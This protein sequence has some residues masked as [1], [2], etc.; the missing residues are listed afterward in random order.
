MATNASE[1]SSTGVHGRPFVTTQW[2]MILAAK[3]KRPHKG[4]NA[5][6]VLCRTYWNP[7][8]GY[9]RG[10][11]YAPADA[12]DLTQSFFE[13]LL[14]RDFLRLVDPEKG[15]FRTFL[16]VAIKRH[17]GHKWEESHARKRGGGTTHVS[18]DTAIIEQTTGLG[19]NDSNADE[20]Y[21]RDWALA[22]L[23]SVT[24][25]LDQEYRDAGGTED[26]GVLR[27]Y[28]TAERG[29]IPYKEIACQLKTSD[30]AARV[31]IHRLRKRFRSL[32]REAVAST[33]ADPSELDDEVRHIITVLSRT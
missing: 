18:L 31:A 16:K 13:R 33:T 9:V 25:Q 32:F 21:D 5:L 14:E 22:L 29:A 26:L 17:L 6:E 3:D 23:R 7:V 15:R 19:A 27:P 30:A 8:Y 28:L 12:Q 10:S 4:A 11:G 24:D 2:S 1:Q 20:L